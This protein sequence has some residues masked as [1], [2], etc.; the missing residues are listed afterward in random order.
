[1]FVDDKKLIFVASDIIQANH[2]REDPR[3]WKAKIA[4]R[5]ESKDS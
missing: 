1:M 5:R 2:N 3:E 4:R